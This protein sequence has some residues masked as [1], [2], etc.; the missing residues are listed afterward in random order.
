LRSF[1]QSPTVGA[2]SSFHLKIHIRLFS[3]RTEKETKQEKQTLLTTK[4]HAIYLHYSLSI[5][6]PGR[7]KV[8]RRQ[9]LSSLNSDDH[10]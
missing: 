1:T 7:T 4:K 2:R 3:T 9:L 8:C 5:I 6:H 10:C